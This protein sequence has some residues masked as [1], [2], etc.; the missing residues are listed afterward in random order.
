MQ[1]TKAQSVARD[2]GLRPGDQLISCNGVDFANVL[3]SEAVSVMK[4]TQHLELV[5]RTAAGRDLFPGESSG[6][7]SSTSSMT[8]GDQSPCWGDPNAKRLSMVREEDTVS[9]K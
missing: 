9:N 3:F 1:F 6:Y 7:N 5:V 8:G 4:A 2:A